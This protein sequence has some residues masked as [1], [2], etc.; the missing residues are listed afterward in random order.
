MGGSLRVIG[1][2]GGAGAGKT[3]VACQLQRRG[4]PIVFADEVGRHVVAK[5]SPVLRALVATFGS[6]VLTTPDGHLDR[7]KVGHWVF[8][9]PLALR[10]LNQL[11]HPAMRCIIEKRLR[12]LAGRGYPCGGVE[13]AVLFEMG[14]LRSVDEVW[15]VIASERERLRRLVR[16][17]VEP[18]YPVRFAPRWQN[19][20]RRL[21][22]QLPSSAFIR[23][24]HRVIVTDRYGAAEA[25]RAHA[26]RQEVSSSC[27]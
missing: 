18:P 9:H 25:L 7:V 17:P 19:M 11:T 15:V 6:G 10:R 3:T 23:R 24:A 26:G 22:S 5:G 20:W 1:L 4:V 21:R 14:L 13:A 12:Q 27:A 8:Q 2:T 16:Q